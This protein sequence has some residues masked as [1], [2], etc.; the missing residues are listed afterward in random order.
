MPFYTPALHHRCPHGISKQFLRL[1]SFGVT[2]LTLVSVE[3][4]LEATATCRQGLY[5]DKREGTGVCTESEGGGRG[6]VLDG[7]NANR[8][9][10]IPGGW[11]IT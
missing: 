6:V 4:S 5:L 7:D 8:P 9:S 10:A 3:G 2:I 11:R 1:D